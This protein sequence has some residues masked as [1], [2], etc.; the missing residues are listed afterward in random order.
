MVAFFFPSTD[1]SPSFKSLCSATGY[2]TKNMLCIP[3]HGDAVA[4]DGN[5]IETSGTNLGCLQ[6][7]NK[8]KGASFTVR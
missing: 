4:H 8:M 3:I 5:A 1:C 6:V 2:T 7:I